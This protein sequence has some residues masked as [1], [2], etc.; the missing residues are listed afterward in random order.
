MEVPTIINAAKVLG[1]EV[2]PDAKPQDASPQYR[3]SLAQSLLYKVRWEFPFL[4]PRFGFVLNP[5]YF[6]SSPF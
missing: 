3:R 5:L 4:L 6:L 1:K 2:K